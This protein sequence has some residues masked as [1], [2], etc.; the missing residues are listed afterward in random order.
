MATATRSARAPLCPPPKKL[1]DVRIDPNAPGFKPYSTRE[2][3]YTEILGDSTVLKLMVHLVSSAQREVIGLAF[4]GPS[5]RQ[6]ELGFEFRFRKGPDSLGYYTSALGGDDYSVMNIYL[7][8]T[9]V[10]FS[11]PL[12]QPLQALLPAPAPSPVAT[13]LPTPTPPA[14]PSA[15]AP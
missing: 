5:T 8:V 9:P 3:F 6:P 15:M 13:A 1:K 14:Q 10:S 2:A 7:D 11:K 12:Y 4:G